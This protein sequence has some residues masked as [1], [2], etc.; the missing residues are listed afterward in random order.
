[1][2]PEKSMDEILQKT[3]EWLDRKLKETVSTDV[4]ERKTQPLDA[5]SLLIDLDTHEKNIR[6]LVEYQ[7]AVNRLNVSLLVIFVPV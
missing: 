4:V 6:E 1:M 5:S 3:R 2:F 7:A